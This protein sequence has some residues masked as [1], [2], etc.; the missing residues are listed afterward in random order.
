MIYETFG[1]E[2]S[3]IVIERNIKFEPVRFPLSHS[4]SSLPNL[5]LINDHRI[6]KQPTTA[7]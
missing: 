6:S 1:E 3:V 7:S 2:V 4:G 5:N